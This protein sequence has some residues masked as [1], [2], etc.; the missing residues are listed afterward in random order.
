[1]LSGTL[2]AGTRGWL[3][4]CDDPQD[5]KIHEREVQR[6]ALSL[7]DARRLSADAP[8]VAMLHYPPFPEPPEQTG[9]TRLLSEY[10]VCVAV[11]GHLHGAST[12]R[13]FNGAFEGV[14]YHLVSCDALG[15]ALHEIAY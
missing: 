14:R 12:S 1:M 8:I 15:F 2:F 5:R 11:Y 13:A 3:C 7:K 6:L 9:F 10:G 4:A